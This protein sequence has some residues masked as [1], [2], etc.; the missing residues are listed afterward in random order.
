MQQNQSNEVTREGAKVNVLLERIALL[1]GEKADLRVELMMY[2]QEL[3]RLNNESKD[4]E[5]A[6]GT[7]EDKD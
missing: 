3:E 6:E 2:A 7:S 1:E 5:K 4:A